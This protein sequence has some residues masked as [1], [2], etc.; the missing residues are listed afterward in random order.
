VTGCCEY[1]NEPSGSIKGWNL[2]SEQLLAHPEGLG[3]METVV[4]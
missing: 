3:S 1:D 4:L 2:L